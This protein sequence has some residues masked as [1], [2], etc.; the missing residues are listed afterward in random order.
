MLLLSR[1]RRR[2]CRGHSTRERGRNTLIG[3]YGGRARGKALSYSQPGSLPDPRVPQVI[4]IQGAFINAGQVVK[5]FRM[6]RNVDD[7]KFTVAQASVIL[8]G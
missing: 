2:P 6:Q 7:S 5:V 1:A 8:R 3:A 4:T